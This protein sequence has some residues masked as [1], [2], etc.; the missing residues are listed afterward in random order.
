MKPKH[1][2]AKFLSAVVVILFSLQL[3]SCGTLIYPERRGQTS[4]RIDVGIAILDGI[5]VLLF[6]IPGLIAF[7]VDFATGAIYLPGGKRAG[8][9]SSEAED[10]VV[11]R[12]NPHELNRKNI[13]DIVSRHTGYRVRLDQENLKVLELEGTANI[14]TELSKLINSGEFS[15]RICSGPF[16]NKI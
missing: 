5:G 12:V 3:V 16:W 6:I 11:I 7:A 13:E 2:W 8:T 9:I 15:D 14:E 10:I 1:R 4:G